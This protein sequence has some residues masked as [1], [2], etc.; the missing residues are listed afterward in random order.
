MNVL[1]Q[2]LQEILNSCF[3]PIEQLIVD[4]ADH[5]NRQPTL[6]EKAHLRAA[7]YWL[8]HYQPGSQASQLEQ[9]RGYLEAAYHLGQLKAWNLIRQTLCI[10][11]DNNCVPLHQQLGIW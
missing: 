5:L 2:G 11:L 10:R 7:F 1:T 3:T 6:G 8:K 4:S 9:V